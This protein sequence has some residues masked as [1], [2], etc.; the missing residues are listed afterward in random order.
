MDLTRLRWRI[1]AAF[2]AA[3][4]LL[5]VT[6]SPAL[7]VTPGKPAPAVTARATSPDPVRIGDTVTVTVTGLHFGRK[8][9]TA[10]FTSPSGE[11]VT[12]VAYPKCSA[13]DARRTPAKC[14]STTSAVLDVLGAWSLTV[15]DGARVLAEQAF[16]VLP[17]TRPWSPP[18]GWVQPDGWLML[19]QKATF[20][21]C[22]TVSWYYDRTGEPEGAGGMHDSVAVALAALA[23]ETGLTFVEKTGTPPSPDGR[24]PFLAYNWLDLAANGH[25]NAGG[26]G[27]PVGSLAGKVSF[28][29]YAGRF[30]DDPVYQ[31]WLATHESMHA[32]GFDHVRYFFSYMYPVML[33]ELKKFNAGDLDGLHTMYKNNPCP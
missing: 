12:R 26:I 32:L 19:A 3:L 30:P 31:V 16:T 13:K 18:D 23:A 5:A 4:S 1:C 27:G 20:T 9:A 24:E 8:A 14:R 29:G 33:Y 21:P 28:P 22:S 25:P 15:T 10:T 11:Q 2:A 7:A 6:G 17:A